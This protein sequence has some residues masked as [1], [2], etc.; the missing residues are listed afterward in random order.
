M[1]TISFTEIT[2]V[3]ASCAEQTFG[4]LVSPFQCGIDLEQKV[5]A[6]EDA[7]AGQHSSERVE[8]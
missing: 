1:A 5:L 8:P 4:Q 6:D 3:D 2:A 7:A